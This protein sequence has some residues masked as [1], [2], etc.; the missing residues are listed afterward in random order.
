MGV[1]FP[2]NRTSDKGNGTLGEADLRVA[3]IFFTFDGAVA[4]GLHSRGA[5]S[6]DL[7]LLAQLVLELAW[8][9]KHSCVWGAGL[10]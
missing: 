3:C 1:N 2:E 6:L 4:P 8:Y 5:V 7:L 9:E 10:G